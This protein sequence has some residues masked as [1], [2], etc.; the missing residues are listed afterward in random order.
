MERHDIS[1]PPRP[2]CQ[3]IESWLGDS[4]PADV[5]QQLTSVGS[6]LWI[7]RVGG[8]SSGAVLRV[9]YGNPN[10]SRAGRTGDILIDTAAPGMWQ[11]TASGSSASA[12][13]VQLGGGA[14]A[15]AVAVLNGSV[16]LAAP[17]LQ[18]M[19]FQESIVLDPVGLSYGN[20]QRY[21]A[22][23]MFS[24]GAGTVATFNGLSLTG[25]N[26]VTD[27]YDLA[28]RIIVTNPSN[29]SSMIMSHA[30]GAFAGTTNDSLTIDSTNLGLEYIN[31]GDLSY[32]AQSG[33]FSSA[34]GGTY[35][36]IISLNG[37]W[38]G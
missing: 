14:A 30:A 32:D 4:D 8:A 20:F 38:A 35:S 7:S 34:S 16:A 24:F 22:S 29:T 37:S 17:S 2:P 19:Q 6:D 15:Q 10:G 23:P 9:G 18:D 5:T 11:C 28:L 31:S 12:T 13:W 21:I 3:N 25:L 27:A 26:T 33:A 1:A 36:V